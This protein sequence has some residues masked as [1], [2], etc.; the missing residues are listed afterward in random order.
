M[1][2]PVHHAMSSAKKFG[3]AWADYIK[4]HEWFDASKA[5]CPDWRHRAMRHHSAG[6]FWAMEVFGYTIK[7]SA[8]KEIPVRAIGEQ[9]VQ[10][11]MGGKIPTIM[12]WLNEMKMQSWMGRLAKKESELTG[13]IKN[14]ESL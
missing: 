13:E 14:A 4:I 3:G 9:H 12:D 6:I 1:S 5:F 7:N 11:D 2:Q 10:E 8:G